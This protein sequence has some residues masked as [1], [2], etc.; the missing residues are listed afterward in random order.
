MVLGG[1]RHVRLPETGKT[2]SGLDM[3]ALNVQSVLDGSFRARTC[4][5]VAVWLHDSLG[6]NQACN[7]RAFHFLQLLVC[8]LRPVHNGFPSKPSGVMYQ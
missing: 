2:S 6:N 4:P 8:R 7:T 5:T 3:E 1:T